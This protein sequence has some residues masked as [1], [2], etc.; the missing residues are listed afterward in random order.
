ME[1]IM[2]P[3]NMQVDIAFLQRT[4]MVVGTLHNLLP[5]FKELGIETRIF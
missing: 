3:T 5:S 4:D 2:L 1:V